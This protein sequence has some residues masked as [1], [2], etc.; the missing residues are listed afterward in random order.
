MALAVF[1]IM[2]SAAFMGLDSTLTASESVKAERDKWKSLTFFFNRME[3][4]LQ[5][6]VSGRPVRMGGGNIA[7]AFVGRGPESDLRAYMVFTRTGRA[8]AQ[9][10]PAAMRRVGYRFTGEQVEMLIWPS[11]DQPEDAGARIYSVM[12]GISAFELYYL[13]DALEWREKWSLPGLPRAVRARV[14]LNSGEEVERIFA[15]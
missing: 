10:E 5:N 11:L 13:D 6:A 8:D 7:Q 3:G 15:L 12:E 2:S 9:G 4:D 1:A 14:V